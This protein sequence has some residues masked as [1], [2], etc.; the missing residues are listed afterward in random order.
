MLAGIDLW[1]L[2]KIMVLIGEGV[3]VVFALV[4]VRQVQLMVSTLESGSL[5]P[6]IKLVSWVLLAGAIALFVF[7]LVLL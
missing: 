6:I 7:S 4:V 1:F 2:I 3:F 5:T